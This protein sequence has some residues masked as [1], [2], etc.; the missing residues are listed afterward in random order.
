M[1]RVNLIHTFENFTFP[2]QV[3]L[4]AKKAR[5]VHLYKMFSTDDTDT[6]KCNACTVRSLSYEGR[7][8]FDEMIP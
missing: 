5:T 4:R 1:T 8:L 3:I 2:Q 6:C 7:T